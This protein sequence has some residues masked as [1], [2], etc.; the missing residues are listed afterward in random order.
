[1][2]EWHEELDDE[3]GLEEDEGVIGK[4][5][6]PEGM[7]RL[8]MN[9][10]GFVQDVH[11]EVDGRELQQSLVP[12]VIEELKR[13][14]HILE[15]EQGGKDDF[16]SLFELVKAKYTA[17]RDTPSERALNEY[18]RDNALFPISDEELTNLWK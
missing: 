6:L 16:I 13:I 7:S 3:P 14:F 9:M 17:I 5:K 4:S 15:R 1:M 10:F 12:D 18:I 11:E 2:R 8:D